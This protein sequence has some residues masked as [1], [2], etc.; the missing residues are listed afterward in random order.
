[1]EETEKQIN[2]LSD[3]NQRTWKDLRDAM[4]IFY[5]E[6]MK[7]NKQAMFIKNRRMI[8]EIFTFSR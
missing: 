2:F 3:Q 4:F 8:N 7:V 1:M 6:G 5:S